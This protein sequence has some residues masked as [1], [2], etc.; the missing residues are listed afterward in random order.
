VISFGTVATA[1]GRCW[2]DPTDVQGLGTSGS[3]DVLAGT[4]G[5]LAARC[6]DATQAACWA[7]VAHRGAGARL[8]DRLAPVGY[9]ARE[10]ADELVPTMQ[11]ITAGTAG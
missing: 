2:C 1:D 10:L 11:A 5:G 6:G 4:V 9:L 8:A 7:A 3:G